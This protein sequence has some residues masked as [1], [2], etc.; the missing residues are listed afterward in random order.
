MAYNWNRFVSFVLLGFFLGPKKRHTQTH[1][2]LTCK[3]L[4]SWNVL[5]VQFATQERSAQDVLPLLFTMVGFD[6]NGKF[7]FPTTSRSAFKTN[8][9]RLNVSC[10]LSTNALIL[11][12]KKTTETVE[13]QSYF[14][15][16]ANQFWLTEI[17]FVPI[18]FQPDEFMIRNSWSMESCCRYWE[19]FNGIYSSEDLF[20]FINRWSPS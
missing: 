18:W 20:K 5:H 9:I 8:L 3:P 4:E 12:K 10:Y 11:T 19:E 16:S 17:S 14:I 7:T 15:G 6:F 2:F 1:A 13:R